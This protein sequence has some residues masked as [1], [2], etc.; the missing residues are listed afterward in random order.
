MGPGP[1]SARASRRSSR[2]R[3]CSSG[4]RRP[5]SSSRRTRSCCRPTSTTSS[6]RRSPSRSCSSSTAACSQPHERDRPGP[7]RRD[8]GGVGAPGRLAGEGRPRGPGRHPDEGVDRRGIGRRPDDLPG[9]CPRHAQDGSLRRRD[10]ARSGEGAGRPPRPR[11]TQA[12]PVAARSAVL[13]DPGRRPGRRPALPRRLSLRL[14]RADLEPLPA[15]GHHPEGPDQPRARPEGD[16][17]QAHQPQRPAD[18][19]RAR[20]GK[21]VEG[22]RAQPGLRPGRGRQD[23]RRRH[24]TPGRHAALR[25]RLGLVLRLW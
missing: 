22:L 8:R 24:P 2:P 1:R 15:D 5:G 17:G 16:P 25:R 4:S 21:A 7:D 18:R 11:R 19:R 9:L 12:G 23:G 3:T 20:A 13:P 10:P 6:R 14:H